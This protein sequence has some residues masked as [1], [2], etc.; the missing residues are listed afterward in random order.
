MDAIAELSSRGAMQITAPDDLARRLAAEPVTL[1]WG[2]DAT[3]DS[4][5]VGQ[6]V[7]LM[8]VRRLQR[9]VESLGDWSQVRTLRQR[10]PGQ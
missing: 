9:P 2:I 6:L 3:A 1:Y 4:L 7:G 5:H 10:Q 8:V